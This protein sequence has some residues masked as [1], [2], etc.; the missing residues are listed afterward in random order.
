MMTPYQYQKML[1]DEAY[2]EAETETE[3][4]EEPNHDTD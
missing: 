1:D 4:E 3:T 2:A